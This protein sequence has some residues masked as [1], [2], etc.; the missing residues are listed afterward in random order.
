[1]PVVHN[2]RNW[3]GAKSPLQHSL[4]AALGQG[5]HASVAK[6]KDRIFQQNH[7]PGVINHPARF[8]AGSEPLVCRAAPRLFVVEGSMPANPKCILVFENQLSQSSCFDKLR[9]FEEFS[10]N[11]TLNVLV[12]K[13]GEY[14]NLYQDS[15]E[16]M[17]IKIL[18]SIEIPFKIPV[19][20]L[21]QPSYLK[22]G[23]TVEIRFHAGFAD[24]AIIYADKEK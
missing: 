1:M 14:I 19:T 11:S 18:L 7:Y 23:D 16:F 17:F 12:N 21:I 20:S 24:A 5:R 2:N 9:I 6:N 13:Y 22:A 15:N 3:Q 4:Q 10:L 8:A